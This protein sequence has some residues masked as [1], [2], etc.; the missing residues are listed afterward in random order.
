MK[1]ISTL[2]TII[3]VT[4]FTSEATVLTV[5]N[6]SN[7]PGQY[8]SLQAAIDAANDGDTILVAGSSTSY[9]DIDIN[10]P[11]TIIGA[12][13]H[14]PYGNNS[15]LQYV[16]FIRINA[17]N[18]ASGSKIS[19]FECYQLR[20]Y[21]SFTGGDINTQGIDDVTVERC[22][23]TS[24]INFSSSSSTYSNDTIRNCILQH[25][26]FYGYTSNVWDTLVIHNNIFNGNYIDSGTS[27]DLGDVF[28]RNNLFINRTTS[29][30]DNVKNMVLENN[31]FYKAEP[32]GCSG[33][34]FNNNLTYYNSNNTIPYGDNVGSG[35]IVDDDPEFVNYPATGGAFDWAHDFHLE[36]TSPAIG[37][38]VSGND[39]GIYGL[40]LPY[41]VGDNPSIPQM[42][43]ITFQNGVSS[44]EKGGNLNVNFKA[45][46]QD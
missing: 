30:F 16:D 23:I 39:I 19:G 36:V 17:D 38:G 33:C 14:N 34:T 31:I 21:G 8:T 28:L 37:T 24:S 2:L 3:L 25:L 32:T 10:R 29:V 7:S 35:N 46:K 12:G 18:S 6:N 20:F 22:N 43:E 13:Y 4:V 1:K 45:K 27:I 9:G 41:E 11:L 15:I 42:I 26:D 44:V 5:S 40:P